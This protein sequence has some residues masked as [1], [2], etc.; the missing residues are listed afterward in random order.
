MQLRFLRTRNIT[1][2]LGFFLISPFAFGHATHAQ[3]PV[4]QR[5]IIPVATPG[6]LH[7]DMRTLSSPMHAPISVGISSQMLLDPASKMR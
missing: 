7:D 2:I 4:Q 5:N 1:K 6:D 3:P